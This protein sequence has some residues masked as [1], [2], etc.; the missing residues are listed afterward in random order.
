M[1]H[2]KRIVATPPLPPRSAT[3][4]CSS[5]LFVRSSSRHTP[6]A[7]HVSSRFCFRI[8]FSFFFVFVFVFLRHLICRVRPVEKHAFPVPERGARKVFRSSY[9]RHF[10]P[11]DDC[12]R[13]FR[14]PETRP[15][16]MTKY[17]TEKKNKLVNND[18]KRPRNRVTGDVFE[19]YAISNYKKYRP[20]YR[21]Y[22]NIY[23][24]SR[25]VKNS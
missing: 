10:L 17:E 11:N 3:F 16:P 9:A 1:I 21:E 12:I 19:K 20:R 18:K 7:I 13:T 25:P 23:I 24:L 2:P 15:R 6:V 22:N 4:F 5:A 8:C 14:R